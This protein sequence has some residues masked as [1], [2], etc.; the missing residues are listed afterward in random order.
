MAG[1]RAR[2]WR[3]GSRTGIRRRLTR[4][5]AAF[6]A[7]ERRRAGVVT[8]DDLLVLAA[9]LLRRSASA[10]RDL[11]ERWRFLL[12]D[13]FQDT[14][15][16]QA[17]VVFLLAAADPAVD[18]WRRAVPR[19]GALF[20]VG[21]PKQSIYRF[22]R[23]DLSVYQ[24]VQMRFRDFGAVLR[25]TT[26][27]R[28]SPA[29]SAFVNTVFAGL[30]PP[31]DEERRPAFSP[32]AVDPVREGGRVGWYRVDAEQAPGRV[33]GRRVAVP[34]AAALASWIA[35]R[36]ASG[37]RVPGD[38]MIITRTRHHL[39]EYARALEM[40]GLPVRMAGG[41][42]G[43]GDE[44][45][46][47]ALLLRALADPGDPV[48]TVAV[49]EGPFFGLSH[50]DLHAHAAGGGA[51]CFTIDPPSPGA[52]ATALGEMR[53]MARM[54]SAMPADAA[55]EAIVDR[56]GLLPLA[57]TAGPGTSDADALLS[58]LESLRAA[59]PG[60]LT[61]AAERLETADEPDAPSGPGE[62]DGV[63][64]TNLHR[65]KG[66]EAPVVILACPSPVAASP[67]PLCAVERGEDGVA[68]GWLFARDG[69]RRADCVLARPAR[70]DE[71]AT[72]E[73]AWSDAEEV[74]LL[75]VAATRARDELVIA[76]CERT[77]GSSVWRDFHPALDDPAL[78]VELPIHAVPP[79]HRSMLDGDAASVIAR[80]ASLAE[81]RRVMALPT[82]R[83]EPQPGESG[84]AGGVGDG[85]ASWRAI[86]HRTLAAAANGASADMLR[87]V[88][89]DALSAGNPHES[90]GS[91]VDALFAFVATVRAS[92][93]WA[94]CEA[95]ER[96]RVAVP[97]ALRVRADEARTLGTTGDREER[98]GEPVA[99][100][101]ALVE[102]VIDLAFRRSGR[103]TL[104]DCTTFANCDASDDTE[105]V[106]CRR[107]LA[108][109][110][111]CWERITGE[112]VESSVMMPLGTLLE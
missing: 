65:A 78:A 30:L 68:R 64:V 69:S 25:L 94:E 71:H 10:R 62:R 106:R 66:L 88:C 44:R 3:H 21:D 92:A 38:F 90:E 83:C 100:C 35:A 50:D 60:S 14:D 72:A 47:L 101:D 105:V 26:S 22:R 77:A 96:C 20:V 41:R 89:R 52:V 58:A 36:V 23:A 24:A 87:E 111:T 9:S 12:V 49:L 5:A 75:Y 74:R 13:E 27:F 70:W 93:I 29:V 112:P 103:W 98:A 102:G 8:F 15:P 51:F 85:A 110:A 33:S 81:M 39:A 53:D 61:E 109:H 17:E 46:E 55:V 48:R 54:A 37:E 57:A 76:R 84:S 67:P 18:D 59:G 32:L 31:A 19:A 56:I 42:A 82:C 34:D 97:F 16:L 28:A 108:L 107:R 1:P 45:R 73:I 4:A 79:L 11:G 2:R 40:R 95:A 91:E 86:I 104:V 99:D 43:A 63:R 7:R 6:C 80:A